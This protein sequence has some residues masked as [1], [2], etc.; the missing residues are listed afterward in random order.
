MPESV[1]EYTARPLLGLTAAQLRYSSQE[2]EKNLQV[3]LRLAKKWNA[4]VLVENADDYLE[5]EGTQRAVI[6]RALDYF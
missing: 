4:I 2:L 1:A 6:L 5:T 3:W